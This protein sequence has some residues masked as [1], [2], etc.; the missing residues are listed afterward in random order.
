MKNL[1]KKCSGGGT[2]GMFG[3]GQIIAYSRHTERGEFVFMK[4]SNKELT[5]KKK[6]KDF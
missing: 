1:S 6:E 4:G 2:I 5:R 3:R